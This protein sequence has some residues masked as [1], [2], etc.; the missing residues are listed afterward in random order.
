MRKYQEQIIGQ[1]RIRTFAREG[2][3]VGA[4]TA[5]ATPEVS[6]GLGFSVTIGFRVR[7]RVRV[8]ITVTVSIHTASYNTSL[9]SS[10]MLCKYYRYNNKQQ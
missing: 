10:P 7:L 4:K 8:R 2:I 6:L 1:G 5:P 9:I 3:G